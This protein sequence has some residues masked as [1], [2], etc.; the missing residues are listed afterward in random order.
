MGTILQVFYSVVLFKIERV[1]NKKLVISESIQM[2]L[3]TRDDIWQSYRL[4]VEQKV[5][6]TVMFNNKEITTRR[7]K[8]IIDW[9]ERCNT[10]EKKQPHH[11]DNYRYYFVQFRRV[12]S[13]N[14]VV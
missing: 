2:K 8:M 4:S 13:K 11:Q 9:I 3:S 14:C 12:C 5:Y 7:F 1:S 6:A 10:N